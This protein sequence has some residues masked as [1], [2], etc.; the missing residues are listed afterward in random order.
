MMMGVMAQYLIQS[1]DMV[2]A[3]LSIWS[4]L[5]VLVEFPFFLI[6]YDISSKNFVT[7]Q[8]ELLLSKVCTYLMQINFQFNLS[9]INV[10]L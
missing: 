8:Y 7:S 10:L 9:F 6:I 2:L 5:S 3:V 1:R 4:L